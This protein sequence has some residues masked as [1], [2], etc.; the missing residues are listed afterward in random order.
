[1]S[2]ENPSIPAVVV[3][4]NN[5]RL[6]RCTVSPWSGDLLVT[7]GDRTVERTEAV[8][9]IDIVWCDV[10]KIG[11]GVDKMIPARSFDLVVGEDWVV[12]GLLDDD[13]Y[14]TL[15]LKSRR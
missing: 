10:V 8:T 13:S 2:F 11:G 1:M 14:G 15:S 3:G 4:A 6:C 9:D 5:G 12:V 7:S